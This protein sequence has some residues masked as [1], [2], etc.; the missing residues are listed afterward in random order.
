MMLSGEQGY[1]PSTWKGHKLE[2][3]AVKARKAAEKASGKRASAESSHNFEAL[4]ICL[5]G[6]VNSS[7]HDTADE[8]L[9]SE[10]MKVPPEDS[11]R[12]EGTVDNSAMV[13]G[14]AQSN[15][16][17]DEKLTA[18]LTW[19]SKLLDNTAAVPADKQQQPQTVED[20]TNE[21]NN[22]QRTGAS[23]STPHRGRG[24][25]IRDRPD[26]SA[27]ARMGQVYWKEKSIQL[28][29]EWKKNRIGDRNPRF[30]GQL[31]LRQRT[32]TKAKFESL[33]LTLQTCAADE[34]IEPLEFSD[35]PRKS[36]LGWTGFVVRP[37]CGSEFRPRIRAM[38]PEP[39]NTSAKRVNGL[40]RD[41][42]LVP[43]QS[44]QEAWDG[45]CAFVFNVNCDKM[46]L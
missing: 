46:R 13:S 40:L 27:K 33:L 8:A 21:S 39:L 41:A 4:M 35:D 19:Q 7:A 23:A 22:S 30:A 6:L 43:S 25:H 34:I 38:F 9:K 3:S 2:L 36:F 20:P 18:P 11:M 10:Q 28:L 12:Q 5:T 32:N 26:L 17:A 37:S 16:I 24:Q 44:W 45:R 42:K 31:D 1:H 15:A 29:E 14:L